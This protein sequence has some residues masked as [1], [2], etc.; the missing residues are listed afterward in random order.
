LRKHIFD[1]NQLIVE[2]LFRDIKQSKDRAVSDRVVDVQA[3]FAT[4]HDIASAQDCE[5]LG[6]RALFNLQKITELIHPELS[7][8][9]CI[10]NGNAERMSQGFEE[11]SFESPQFRHTL[12]VNHY[13]YILSNTHIDA[14]L[15]FSSVVDRGCAA[16][17]ETAS[18]PQ[19]RWDWW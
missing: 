6:Q 17:S 2:Y 10:Q 11:F 4:G 16:S 1:P 12:P 19:W 8:A 14:G 18:D 9:K 7:M 15:R 3:F 13:Y 5:L